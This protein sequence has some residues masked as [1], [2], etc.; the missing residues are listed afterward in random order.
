MQLR[1][2]VITGSNKGGR[3]RFLSRTNAGIVGR[4]LYAMGRSESMSR[5]SGVSSQNENRTSIGEDIR[6]CLEAIDLIVLIGVNFLSAP[7]DG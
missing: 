5:S 4:K 7:M 6:L 3:H 2:R 1:Q